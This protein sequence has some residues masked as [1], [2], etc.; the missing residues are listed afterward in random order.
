MKVPLHT[1]LKLRLSLYTALIVI[2]FAV[3]ISLWLLTT[4]KQEIIGDHLR[5]L[6]FAGK[7]FSDSH[8]DRLNDITRT[9]IALNKSIEARIG[10][11]EKAPPSIYKPSEIKRR[12]DGAL[13]IDDGISGAFLAKSSPITP[14]S[15]ISSFS[16]SVVLNSLNPS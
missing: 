16:Q 10:S 11:G 6:E 15:I 9:A 5:Q 3:G 13:R 1:T 4:E 2:I 14:T 12:E 7:Q 8:I